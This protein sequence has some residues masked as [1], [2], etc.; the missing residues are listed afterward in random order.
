M[1]ALLAACGHHHL[2]MVVAAVSR[3]NG[4]TIGFDDNLPSCL[5]IVNI[6]CTHNGAKAL[7]LS[8]FVVDKP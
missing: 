4:A 5:A 2:F 3:L 7:F 8:A 1:F 6:A